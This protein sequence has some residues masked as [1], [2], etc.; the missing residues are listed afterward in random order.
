MHKNSA[1]DKAQGTTWWN[2]IWNVILEQGIFTTSD[3]E[4]VEGKKKQ[5]K[6]NSKDKKLLS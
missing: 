4:I 3:F 6:A 1:L 2:S 5:V